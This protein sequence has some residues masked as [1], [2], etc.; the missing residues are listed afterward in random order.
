MATVDIN[1]EVTKF[2]YAYKKE[3][4][5][6]FEL[7]E[8]AYSILDMLST[9][10][11]ELPPSKLDGRDDAKLLCDIVSSRIPNTPSKTGIY[12]KKFAEIDGKL[13][14]ISDDTPYDDRV[15]PVTD[16]EMQFRCACTMT[17]LMDSSD[18]YRD[19]AEEHFTAVRSDMYNKVREDIGC[20]VIK[21]LA[22]FIIWQDK[23]H[24]RVYNDIKFGLLDKRMLQNPLL[25][26][27]QAIRK[28][29]E[30]FI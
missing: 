20:T 5:K 24:E 3:V 4:F 22:E 1:F 9:V 14:E 17:M 7:D 2:M 12:P 29:I 16:P 21:K 19:F 27:G 10:R 23:T 25:T 26:Y 11:D 15:R 30:N 13:T 8:S 6:F 28:N 18:I